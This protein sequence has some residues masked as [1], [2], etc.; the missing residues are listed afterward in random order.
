M[1]SQYVLSEMLLTWSNEG[2]AIVLGGVDVESRNSIDGSKT[3]V[4]G[5]P[6]ELVFLIRGSWAWAY[7]RA[8]FAFSKLCY[9]QRKR[10][11]KSTW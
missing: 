8:F 4:T 9:Q 1:K 7:T 3:S 2:I 6:K 11:R 10:L 5:V